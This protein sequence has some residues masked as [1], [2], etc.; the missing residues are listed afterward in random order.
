MAGTKLADIKMTLAH[1]VR[2]TIK[3]DS[4]CT[5]TATLRGVR[6]STVAV[7]KQ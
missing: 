4:Q 1:E 5:H 7:E 2:V 3:Q 6:A